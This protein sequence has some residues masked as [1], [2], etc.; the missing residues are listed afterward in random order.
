MGEVGGFERGGLDFVVQ[1][2][3]IS[4]LLYIQILLLLERQVV[5]RL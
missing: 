5:N 3:F 2:L 1:A 4:N